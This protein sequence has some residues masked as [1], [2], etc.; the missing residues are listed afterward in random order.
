MTQTEKQRW[1]AH[2]METMGALASGI[3]HD[4]NNILA[5][6]VGYSELIKEDLDGLAGVDEKTCERLDN[7]MAAS[8]RAKELIRQILTFS[9]AEQ[10][11]KVLVQVD[12]LIREVVRFLRA[13]LPATVKIH[14]SLNATGAVLAAPAQIHQ[15]LINLCTN[16]RDAM[17]E[18]VG[19]LSISLDDMDLAQM[20]DP[21]TGETL[22]G[23]FVRI[24]VADTG[25]GIDPKIM[26]KVMAPFFTTK[27]KDR[28]S[29]MGLAV[30]YGIVRSLK[31]SI[32]VSSNHP[33]GT[34]FDIFLPAR[35]GSG[36][37]AGGT[38]ADEKARVSVTTGGSEHILFVDDEKTLTG[39]ARDSLASL[40][41]Q[42]TAFTSSLE[43]LAYFKIH[44]DRIDLVISD[45]TMPD[46]PGDLL[47]KRMQAICPALGVIL[48]TG[49]SERMD[50]ARAKDLG[51][52]ALLY[53]PV[54]INKMA[55]TIR[56]VLKLRGERG[57]YPDC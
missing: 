52:G 12:L 33:R 11:E 28:G 4:F 17:A 31:G 16:A 2:R 3:A 49:A 18:T 21:D 23:P 41:Y 29:G 47:V 22:T 50:R 9:R 13:S 32:R 57:Q 39:L 54:P 43:A 48:I 5:G 1:Y 37:K 42:V 6:I 46:L 53:K 36:A 26:G 25:S 24:R 35:P 56:Q 44:W 40:G 30:V 45:I 27:P 19:T 20:P 34:R 15:I 14:H 7:I 38:P 10:E 8:M 51:M 55:A